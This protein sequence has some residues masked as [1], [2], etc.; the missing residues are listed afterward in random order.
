MAKPL[1]SRRSPA[2]RNA[3][4]LANQG[5][6]YKVARR[7][8][9]PTVSFEDRVSAGQFGLIRAAD[10]FDAE[11][12]YQFSTYAVR[13]IIQA[14][15]KEIPVMGYAVV[16]PIHLSTA[17]RSKSLK[18]PEGFGPKSVAAAK[19]AKAAAR[20]RWSE[21]DAYAV[22]PDD[23][24]LGGVDNRDEISTMLATLKPSHAE[25]LRKRFGIDGRQAQTL[26]DIGRTS[27]V[28]REYIRQLS[29]QAIDNLRSWAANRPCESNA[30]SL[31]TGESV[32]TSVA[33]DV[34]P[35]GDSPQ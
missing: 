6:V 3:L 15:Q 21:A 17:I 9:H 34:T 14:I 5:L 33:P 4:V 30:K 26:S 1:P 19:L 23:N 29:C 24:A 22:A 10:L 25:I 7:M 12:G 20:I 8:A 32:A 27:G 31:L 2:E 16:I 28:S 35:A 18:L 11:L 13:H